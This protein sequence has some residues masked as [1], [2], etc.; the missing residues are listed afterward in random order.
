LRLPR[1]CRTHPPSFCFIANGG[2]PIAYNPQVDPTLVLIN[3]NGLAN[4]FF[5]A[6]DKFLVAAYAD[7]KRKPLVEAHLQEM[8][9]VLA[10]VPYT[11]PGE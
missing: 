2:P 1:P 8:L 7:Q 11:P 3:L 10:T 9:T 4:A 6:I 5:A